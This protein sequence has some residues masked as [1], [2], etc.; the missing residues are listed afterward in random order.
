M[1]SVDRHPGSVDEDRGGHGAGKTTTIAKLT[2]RFQKMGKKYDQYA[3]TQMEVYKKVGNNLLEDIVKKRPELKELG[4]KERDLIELK[5]T[6]ERR[7]AELSKKNPLTLQ[8]ATGLGLAA[9]GGVITGS[10]LVGAGILGAEYALTNPKALHYQAQA[11]AKL[12][13]MMPDKTRVAPY[14]FLPLPIRESN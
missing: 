2:H 12:A 6:I 8:K 5:T 11:L 13:K 9:G 3:G 1:Q 10:P 7:V 4:L 14:N